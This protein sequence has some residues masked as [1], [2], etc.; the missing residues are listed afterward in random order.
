MKKKL[1]TWAAAVLMLPL[2]VDGSTNHSVNYAGEAAGNIAG[3]GVSRAAGKRTAGPVS[4]QPD[5]LEIC[6]GILQQKLEH[7]Y[8]VFTNESKKEI[9]E[10][11]RTDPF[12][13]EVMAL[14]KHYGERS[15]LTTVEPELTI[16]DPAARYTETNPYLDYQMF[17]LNG[18]YNLAFLYQMTGE[19]AYADRAFYFVNKLCAMDTWVQSAHYFEIIYPRVWPYGVPDDQVS[20]SYDISVADCAYVVGLVYD[21]LYPA[22][23]KPQ[24]DRI[25]GALLEKAIT[26]VRGNYEYQWWAM[27]Y[28]CNWSGICH[29]GVGMAALALLTE[30]PR[31]IDVL[32]R[33]CEGVAGMF[34]H[35]G[36]DNGWGEGRGYAGYGL[37]QSIYFMDAIKKVSGGK[38][39]LFDTEGLK[40][41]A[42]FALFG[43]TGSFNDGEAAG[44]IG[45]SYH[46]NKLVEES[47][48]PTAMYYLETYLNGDRRAKNMW[49]LIWPRPTDIPAVKPSEAS[50][51]FPS[52]DWAFMRRDF[53]DSCM[54]VA[55]KCA[56]ADDPHHGHLDAGSVNL[57]WM[58]DTFVGE[59]PQRYYDQYFFNEMRWDYLYV[60]SS[61]HN[62]VIV[63]GEEQVSGKH[64]DQP[65]QPGVGGRIEKFVTGPAFDYVVMDATKAYPGEKLKSWKRTVIL[66][67]QTD[68]VL[69]LDRVGCA[70]GAKIEVLFHPLVD[71]TV[72]DGESVTLTGKHAS[73]DMQT[74][75]EAPYRTT[76]EKQMSFRIV[77]N[78]PVQ[79]HP[80][81][82]TTLTAPSEMNVIGTV[83]Y[84]S[85]R[86]AAGAVYTLERSGKVPVIACTAG[87]V[88]TRYAVAED[89]VTRL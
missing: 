9:L 17:Y 68:A 30:E 64:K 12:A 25:R 8:L 28:K 20:F 75:S 85:A 27:A 79:Y 18:A 89:G 36:A 44:P 38:I 6:R 48:D 35:L 5:Y 1:W 14:L 46:Y 24:R 19:Q 76:L 3:N 73:V 65:W 16:N 77:K 34:A 70:K 29:S 56:L 49:E 50:K 37:G 88:T 61:G 55:A 33:S 58:G 81:L 41:P 71:A 45:T 23:A 83:F 60:K 80:C 62:T 67:K 42:D 40:H 54:Q 7:P 2:V 39:D 74:L 59:V 15:M 52:I 31:L 84:P 72:H 82:Y 21:W 66:D 57:T 51:Y 53:S 26:R 10:R 63:D 43:L 86:K 4:V 13:A 32:A 87:G 11:V 22:L 78:D 47:Q 69:V